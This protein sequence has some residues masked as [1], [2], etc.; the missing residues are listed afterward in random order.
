[1]TFTR[2]SALAAMG[3][4]LLL[5]A[6]GGRGASGGPAIRVGS[7]NFTEALVIGEIYAQALEAHGFTVQRHLNLGSVQICMAALEHGDIDLYP[8]Y[9][10][11]ALIDVLHHAPISDPAAAYAAVKNAYQKQFHATWLN[12][13]PMNDSQGLVTT[14]A[15]STKYHFTTL[16][17]LAP[18]APQLRLAAIAEFLGRPD[19]I[20]GLQ[21]V[22]GGFH[23]K[24]VK[25]YDAGLKY[26]ALLHGDADVAQAFTTDGQIGANNL[27]LL[28]DDK[29]LWPPYNV[30]PVVRLDALKAHPQIATALNAVAPLITDAAARSMN[31]A[32]D[33]NKSDPAEVAARFLKEHAIH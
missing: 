3:A 20:P 19:G 24:D 21:R 27:V 16:S 7:K 2:K 17:Q 32:V 12:P 8:E 31:Y 23:F 9:T 1:M 4:T 18:L 10:G 15:I 11:T 14:Q 25:T 28:A 30:A 5:P 29:H 26:D 33:H 6:C 22:Y 13:S